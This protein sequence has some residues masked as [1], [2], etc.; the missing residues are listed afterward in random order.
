MAIVS[1]RSAVIALVLLV[2][3]AYFYQAGGWNANSRFDLVRAIVEQGTVVIDAYHT[4]TGD[5]S[6]YNGHY[7]TDKA[8]G[9]R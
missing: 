3:Y 6:R 9:H 5:K 8:P 2:S 7:Y 1:R 4:N